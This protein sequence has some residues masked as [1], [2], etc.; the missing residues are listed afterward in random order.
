[1]RAIFLTVPAGLAL[2]CAGLAF[3]VAANRNHG[4]DISGFVAPARHLVT[5]RMSRETEAAAFR[6]VPTFSVT[7]S[8]GRAVTIGAKDAK[9]PQFVYFIL[10]GC[11]CSFDAE[12]L[13][14][15]MSHQFAGAVDF[16]SVTD[17]T[18]A[19]AHD[20]SVQLLVNYP[21]VPDPQKRIIHAF[22]AR[23]SVYSALVS[24]DGHIVKMWPGYSAGLLQEMNA[25]LAKEAGIP[26]R[27][28][29]PE[30]APKV[31]ATGC[32]F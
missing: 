15:K 3:V 13:F 23:S 6:T 5:A 25:A 17:A 21:V 8:E 1:M 14:H 19:K 27:P 12:P 31:K 28:F 11:P 16:I 32:A 24:R 7:D 29:D 30:Y 4:E 18:R 20:W 26:E 2:G 10:D 22:G 9:R